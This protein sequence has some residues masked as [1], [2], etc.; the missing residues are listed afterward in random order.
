MGG[1]E[2]LPGGKACE[3]LAPAAE[4]RLPHPLRG[5]ALGEG[6]P[7]PPALCPDLAH[8]EALQELGP[9]GELAA[10]GAAGAADGLH[11]HEG[12]GEEAV[13]Q[14]LVLAVRRAG[15]QGWGGRGRAGASVTPAAALRPR[16]VGGGG[17]G[18]DVPRSC[19]GRRRSSVTRCC[20]PTGGCGP[21]P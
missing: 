9:L 4:P 3:G 13:L 18:P 14:G 21:G 16:G 1:T 10:T 11:Q 20:P 15:K 17:P 6:R 12:R 7:A 5:A 2:V 8:Q 19:S